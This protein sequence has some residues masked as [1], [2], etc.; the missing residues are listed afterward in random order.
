M[1]IKYTAHVKYSNGRTSDFDGFGYTSF[2]DE[3]TM[4][5]WA[6]EQLRDDPGAVVTVYRAFTAEIYR[7]YQASYGIK[8]ETAP[9]TIT[10]EEEDATEE[11]QEAEGGCNNE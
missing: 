10:T 8:L 5:A 9:A 11:V 1:K 4:D 2:T 7:T 6:N 3:A